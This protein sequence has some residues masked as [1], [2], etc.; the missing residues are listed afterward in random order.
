MITTVGYKTY[1]VKGDL[2]SSFSTA[3]IGWF[4]FTTKVE[5]LGV[6]MHKMSAAADALSEHI[7]KIYQPVREEIEALHDAAR[8]RNIH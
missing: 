1:L 5:E 3:T 6:S 8:K 4:S 2:I 7:T